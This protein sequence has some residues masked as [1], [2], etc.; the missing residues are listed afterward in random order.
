MTSKES[1][2]TLEP[3]KECDWCGYD[4]S[5]LNEVFEVK[6]HSGPKKGYRFCSEECTDKQQ[7]DWLR[8]ING[9]VQ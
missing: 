9:E 1:T 5:K 4:L 7:E 3:S 8:K 6:A 2:L